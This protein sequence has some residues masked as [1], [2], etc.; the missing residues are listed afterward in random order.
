MPIHP[1]APW[2]P[3]FWVLQGLAGADAHQGLALGGDGD[4]DGTR[5]FPKVLFG[6]NLSQLSSGCTQGEQPCGSWR[7]PAPPV[8]S[9]G[10][11]SILVA[12]LKP[13]VCL[14]WM[15]CTRKHIRKTNDGLCYASD[16]KALHDPPV[17]R[18]WFCKGIPPDEHVPC[19]G[20]LRAPE[21]SPTSATARAPLP[22]P[23][24]APSLRRAP[25]VFTGVRNLFKR[26][27][28]L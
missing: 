3:L 2:V 20:D 17:Q 22:A 5:G 7:C 23:P 25:P 21:G 8:Q 15:R 9:K 27:F 1:G 19:H 26:L 24:T 16:P 11:C 6:A 12:V 18:G 28:C 14:G 10:C 4:A 13:R